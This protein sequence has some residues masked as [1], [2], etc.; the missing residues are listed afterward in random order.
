MQA[1]GRMSSKSVTNFHDRDNFMRFD[2][3]RKFERMTC[4]ESNE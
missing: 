4:E 1:V 3:K 2:F